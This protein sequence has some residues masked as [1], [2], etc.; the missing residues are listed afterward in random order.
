[1]QEKEYPRLFF[2]VY[3]NLVGTQSADGECGVPYGLV[4]LPRLDERDA[5]VGHAVGYVCR[6]TYPFSMPE[7]ALTERT[8]GE[9]KKQKTERYRAYSADD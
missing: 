9:R 3:R 5:S 1:M 6:G 2:A 4:C 7:N 8:Y